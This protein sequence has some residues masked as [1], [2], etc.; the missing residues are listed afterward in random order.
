MKNINNFW[1]SLDSKEKNQFLSLSFAFRDAISL[2]YRGNS[3]SFVEIPRIKKSYN[4]NIYQYDSPWDEKN[5]LSFEFLE[6]FSARSKMYKKYI[7]SSNFG[8]I[9]K[10]N[11]LVLSW[12]KFF[13]NYII[14]GE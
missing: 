3:G 7:I 14:F 5:K 9:T 8:Q 13:D 10:Y 4:S 2:N 6:V 1:N 11:D 12:S